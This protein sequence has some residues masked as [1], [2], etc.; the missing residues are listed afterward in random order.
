MGM[1]SSFNDEDN[2]CIYDRLLNEWLKTNK[3]ENFDCLR[4]WY[5]ENKKFGFE[6]MD[7][8]KTQGYWYRET[9]IM[10]KLLERFMV[11]GTGTGYANFT[12]EEGQ[13][14]SFHLDYEQRKIS[15]HYVPLEWE[16]M[17]FELNAKEERKIH[18]D[19]KWKKRLEAQRV[20]DVL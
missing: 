10:L 3:D 2:I 18:L 15:L 17:E 9:V 14:F 7:G 20:L 6:M 13:P 16:T 8:W 11:P 4:D 1:R 5:K 12:Y 19:R